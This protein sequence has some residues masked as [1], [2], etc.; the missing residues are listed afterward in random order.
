MTFSYTPREHVELFTVDALV[1]VGTVAKDLGDWCAVTASWILKRNRIRVVRRLTAKHSDPIALGV[2][3]DG[4]QVMVN[5]NTGKEISAP[6][7]RDL[8][9][10]PQRD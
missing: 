10:S 1:K 7:E 8:V 5:F 2:R 6:P 3:A 9:D 4:T